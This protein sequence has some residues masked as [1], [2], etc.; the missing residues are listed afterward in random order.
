MAASFAPVTRRMP[1]W[2]RMKQN[3]S[4]KKFRMNWTASSPSYRLSHQPGRL[5]RG[6]CQSPRALQSPRQRLRGVRTSWDISACAQTLAFL[7]Y[8]ISLP[9][10]LS[11]GE[12]QATCAHELLPTPQV[13]ANV[14]PKEEK[15]SI[16]TPGRF[17]ELVA[18]L[19]DGFP[20]M[21]EARKRRF[22][23]TLTPAA[24]SSCLSEAEKPTASMTSSIG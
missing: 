17:C 21:M 1:C 22:S 3:A 19:F 18:Y 6:Q 20:P 13:S 24:R 10:A 2:T 16:A 4:A 12:L 8:Q 9:W 14:P 23:R 15:I 11:H 5:R 7:R